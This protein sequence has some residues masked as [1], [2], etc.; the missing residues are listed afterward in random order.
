MHYDPPNPSQLLGR[1]VNRKGDFLCREFLE[2]VLAMARYIYYTCEYDL[3]IET[4]FLFH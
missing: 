1:F 2:I 3:A 4:I